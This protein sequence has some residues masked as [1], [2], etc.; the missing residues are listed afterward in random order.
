MQEKKYISIRTVCENYNV[1][2][3][4]FI[5]LKEIGILTE[6]NFIEKDEPVIEESFLGEIEKIM[7]LHYDLNI[8]LEGIDIIISLI[9]RIEKLEEEL[10]IL[11]QQLELL[12]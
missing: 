11:K 10:K 12:D 4:F 8:N 9:K 5:E 2:E 7:R 3:K 6:P 1:P